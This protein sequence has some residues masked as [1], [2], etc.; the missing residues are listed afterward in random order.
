MSCPKY[1]TSFFIAILSVGG[2]SHRTEATVGP[3]VEVA[4]D[5]Y[6]DTLNSTILLH[7]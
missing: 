3:Y 1:S 6:G 5:S 7:H 4:R 2:L